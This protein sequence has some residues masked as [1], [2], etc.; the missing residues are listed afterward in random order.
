MPDVIRLWPDGAPGSKDSSQ[1]EQVYWFDELWKHRVTRNVTDPSLTV[2][3]PAPAVATGTGVVICP[4]GAH[5]FLA[6]DHEGYDVAEWLTERG[7]AAFVL[8][9]R[10]IETPQDDAEFLQVRSRIGEPGRLRSLLGAHWRLALA[11]GQQAVRTVRGRATEWGLD[12]SRIGIMGFSAGGHVAAGVALEGDGESRVD[13]VAPIYG[14]LWE[15]I[16]VPQDAPPLFLALAS[17]DPIAVGPCLD[18]YRAWHGAGRP[19]E[20]HLYARGGHGV[21][22]VRQGLPSDGWIERFYEWLQSQGL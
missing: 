17:D 13:F 7:I 9:Y 21:G 2:F 10:V 6:V 14:A 1:Q 15:D 22:M 11:D 3:L 5:H 12:A 4:G 16:A 20:L 19:A 18:L 8:K